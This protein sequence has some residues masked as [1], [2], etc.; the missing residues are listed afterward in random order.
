MSFRPDFRKSLRAAGKTIQDDNADRLLKGE[1]VTGEEIAPDVQKKPA[2]GSRKRARVLGVRVP[3]A[4]LSSRPG[5]KS[6]GM[7]KDL[8]RRGNVKVGRTSVKVVPSPEEIVKTRVF[9]AG[10]RGKQVP[11]P[12][13]GISA[14]RLDEIAD[15]VS[16]DGRDQLVAHLQKERES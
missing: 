7:L 10:R 12:F 5:V 16:R 2:S 13:S 15:D 1:S 6:G 14:E 11:R 9:N 8:T 4:Q 3:L